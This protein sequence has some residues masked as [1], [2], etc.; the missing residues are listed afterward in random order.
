VSLEKERDG[1]QSPQREPRIP[2]GASI[3]LLFGGPSSSRFEARALYHTSI[4]RV[5]LRTMN[6]CSVQR[7]AYASSSM[8]RG[9][10]IK[11]LFGTRKNS[12][13]IVM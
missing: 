7:L 3:Y 9:K 4:L 8:Y 5:R 10:T 2:V 6:T 11:F 1:G 12:L 13:W